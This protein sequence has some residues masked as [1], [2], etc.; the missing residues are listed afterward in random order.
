MKT[1]GKIGAGIITMILLGSMLILPMMSALPLNIQSKETKL[2]FAESILE[3]KQFIIDEKEMPADLERYEGDH[4]IVPNDELDTQQA[5]I[6]NQNDI[7]YNV[8]AGN[9][10]VGSLNIYIGE[11][12]DDKPGRGRTGTLEPDN[13]DDQDWYR[14]MVCEGQTIQTSVASSQGYTAELYDIN[15]EAIGTSYTAQETGMYFVKVYANEGAG[16]GAYT[17]NLALSGQNDAGTGDDAGD[18]YS[19]ATT[20]SPGSYVG[21][22]DSTDVEDWYKFQVNSNQGIF[23]HVEPLEKSDYDIHLYNPSGELVH[24]AQYYGEDDLE[25]PA[26]ASGTWTIKLD[27]FPGWD[28][29]KYPEDYFL[30]GS[31]PYELEITLGGTAQVP[32]EP[33]D[34]PEIIPV[35]QTF[36][37][38][39]DPTSTKDEYGYLAAVPAANFVEN[40]QRYVSPIVY[41]GVDTITNWYGTVDD[42][43][44]YLLDDWDTYLSRH[45]SVAEE[46]I[47]DPDPVKAASTIA[48]THWS[49]AS[50]AVLAMDGSTLQDTAEIILEQTSTLHSSTEMTSV[51]PTQLR[52]IGT[53]YAYPLYLGNSWGAIG[54][55]GLGE[56]F[57][58]DVGVITSRYESLMSDWWPYGPDYESGNDTDIYFPII[59]AGIW[60]PFTTITNNLEEMKIFKVPGDRFSLSVGDT[61]SSLSVTVT[62]D[63]PSY[64]R[65]YLID[66]DGNIRRPS[67]PHWNGGEINPIH[68][69]NGGHWEEIGSD[70]WRSLIP[71]ADTTHTVEVHHP[72]AGKW[73]AIVVPQSVDTADVSVSYQIKGELR[74]HNPERIATALSAANAAVIASAI[75]A[76]LLYVTS[77]TIP[78]ETSAAL[79]QL[80]VS[81]IIFVNIDDVSSASPSGTV[82][83][84]QTMQE[85]VDAIQ[86]M[87]TSENYITITSLATG[88]GYFAPAGMIAAY[89]TSPVLSIG[90]APTAYDTIDKL[91]TWEEYAGDYYHGCRSTG[92]LP[93]MDHPFNLGEFIRS[94]L[95]GEFPHPGF[96]LMLR[97]YSKIYD[98]MYSLIQTY[99]LDA[100]GKEAFMFVSPRDT[101]I[102]SHICRVLMG[103]NSFAGQIPVE[104]TAF[105]SALICRNILYPALIYANPGRDVTSTVIMNHWEGYDWT[106]N[107]GQT[108]TS[109][110]TKKLKEYFSSHGRFFDG[111]TIWD[112]ILE[113]YNEG[114]SVIYHT[115]HGT[116][117]SGI[118][119][120]Y[121]NV[122]EQ[123]P[124]M[125]LNHENLRDFDWWDSWRAYY[126][127][128]MKT[129]TPREE[130]RVWFNSEEPNLYDIVHFKW[131][132][133]LFENLHSQI[134]LWQSCTTGAHFGPMI[135]LEHGAVLWYGNANTGRSPQSDMFDYWWFEDFLVKGLPIGEAHSKY[136]WLHDRD[137][138][139]GDPTSIYGVSSMD[140]G[141]RYGDGEGLVNTWVI[142]G[143]P[144]LQIYSPQWTEPVPQTL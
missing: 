108:H 46:Y 90:E 143:D 131:C 20:I 118:C 64:L 68:Y 65:V 83:T 109:V 26:D 87:E 57:G 101:D 5:L 135:Y 66:P 31:G 123:F 84:Y 111:H 92:H 126:Y 69:W 114:A 62:T 10:I 13:N 102:R 95:Q 56:N 106:T 8:D 24:S 124:P 38:N 81:E 49:T 138:T 18:S 53:L 21:Y 77:D 45:G 130:G 80:G 91:V 34:Q 82:T 48:T 140:L 47:V 43:T 55:H 4:V 74:K 60:M 75:H 79:N 96:D 78:G 3:E 116:G 19:G 17:L 105:S 93:L 54:I 141:D 97:W 119:C 37:V 15:A 42:T 89:H 33:N 50:T 144:L 115:S 29:S 125:E 72:M 104:T 132:D 98:D 117:G 85:V 134:N 94:V 58:G 133:Q 61:D 121:R 112:N 35:A 52:D 59:H 36:I 129:S 99:G 9:K 28:T 137:Y 27:I 136:V 44:Q 71:V 32:E 51:S 30:Y 7:G 67:I 127:D 2:S 122:Q 11:P 63:E 88:D 40:G 103:N 73:T 120:M 86:V 142:F 22:M 139:T 1:S 100:D 110:V 23:V 39:D 76:P 12:I 25:F 16:N 128:N 70:D 41:Q 107:D 6:S 14:F 113:Q